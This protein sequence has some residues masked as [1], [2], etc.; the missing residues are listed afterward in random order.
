MIRTIYIDA[1]ETVRIVVRTPAALT[2][3]QSVTAMD[4]GLLMGCASRIIDPTDA[5]KILE[6][7]G[8]SNRATG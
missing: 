2:W 6:E 1:G 8:I 5:I 4:E 7:A 3:Q